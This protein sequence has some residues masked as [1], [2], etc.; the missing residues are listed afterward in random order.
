MLISS[1]APNLFLFTGGGADLVSAYSDDD[2]DYAY[3]LSDDGFYLNAGL[4]TREGDYRGMKGIITYNVQSGDTI[5]GIAEQFG[6]DSATI[7]N[8]NPALWSRNY[9][10]VGQ[11]LYFP[12][13]KGIIVKV[14]KGDTLAS[15][16]K[17]YSVDAKN[18][19]QANNMLD[20]SLVL[21]ANIILPGA[22]QVE[23]AVY[24][25]RDIAASSNVK[26]VETGAKLVW[27]AQGKIMQGFKSGHYAVD[28]ADRSRPPIFA[29]DSGTIVKA[30][31]GW[32]GGYGNHIIIDHGNGMQTLYGHM[33]SL[34]V[35][36]GDTVTRGQVIGV[37]GNTGRVYGVTGI[38]VHFE[39]RINGVKKNPLAYL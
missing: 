2:S 6:I 23:R 24:V 28:I 35:K 20:D 22:K 10:K 32:N 4:S 30:A 17:K 18:I 15:L 29:A 25:T 38:H 16:A 36:V 3:V 27:P 12:S 34:S 5:S 1:I 37:M 11:E 14:G 7:M 31:Y 13:V 8:A 19:Q 39:V 33:Q 26:Y 9:L 21:G